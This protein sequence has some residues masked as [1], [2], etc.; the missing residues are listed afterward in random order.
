MIYYEI[1]THEKYINECALRVW[2]ILKP[3]EHADKCNSNVSIYRALFKYCLVIYL[4]Y[5][6]DYFCVISGSSSP[7]MAFTENSYDEPESNNTQ[8]LYKKNDSKH[9]SLKL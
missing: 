4:E 8:Y 9:G 1:N 5:P 2:M 7:E 3:C 6:C